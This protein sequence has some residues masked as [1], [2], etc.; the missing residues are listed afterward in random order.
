MVTPQGERIDIEERVKIL[1]A[2]AVKGGQDY[3]QGAEEHLVVQET[4]RFSHQIR[5]KRKMTK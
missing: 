2:V 4:R 5:V 1:E 3:P